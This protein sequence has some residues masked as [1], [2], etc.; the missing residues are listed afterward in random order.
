M[1]HRAI[2]MKP[3]NVKPSMYIYFNKENNKDGPKYEI[4]DKVRILTYKNLLAKVYIPNWSQEVF[5]INGE[6]VILMEKKL[7]K[8]FTKKNSKK[9]IKNS[10]E[11]KKK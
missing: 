9:Q 1:Y 4:R 6:L 8:R 11:L 2:K 7:L 10:L 3:A 5:V